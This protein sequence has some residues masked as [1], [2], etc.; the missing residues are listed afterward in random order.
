MN[1]HIRSVE[2]I[3]RT[4]PALAPLFDELRDRLRDDHGVTKARYRHAVPLVD[5]ARLAVSASPPI[6][7][8]ADDY[9]RNRRHEVDFDLLERMQQTEPMVWDR[10]RRARP[11][12]LGPARCASAGRLIEREAIGDG[13]WHGFD[14][15][16]FGPRGRRG[17]FKINAPLEQPL[18]APT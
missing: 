12:R 14:V 9:V 1:R 15:A 10:A 13:W 6:R 5:G 3:D 4:L 16:V 7:A 18:D 17:L 8:L 11:A 2:V